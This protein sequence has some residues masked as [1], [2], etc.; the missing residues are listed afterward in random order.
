MFHNVESLNLYSI[1]AE[2]IWQSQLSETCYSTANLKSL[3]V[4]GCGSLEH[5]LS[6]SIARSLGQLAHF[7]IKDCRRL[8]EIISTDNIEQ[9]ENVVICFPLLKSLE[10]NDLRNLIHFCGGNY[11]I[12]FPALEE[13]QL[14][15]C[16]VLKGFINEPEMD[17]KCQFSLQVLFN[18]KVNK[19]KPP[20]SLFVFLSPCF[21]TN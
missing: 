8:R 1:S 15:D 12:E 7:E 18:E 9:E 14:S 2:R 13:M 5:L 16:P 17:E 21:E 10:I 4:D 11:N 6:P 19:V 3:I 20:C